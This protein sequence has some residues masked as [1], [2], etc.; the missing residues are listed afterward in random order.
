[1]A[2]PRSSTQVENL[3]WE[4]RFR[5][6]HVKRKRRDC[7]HD[8][9][10]G[11]WTVLFSYP[12]DFTPVCATELGMISK[13]A[14]EFS[15]RNCKIIG[16]SMDSVESHEAWIKDVNETQD[17]EVDFPLIMTKKA[18]SQ[19]LGMCP[20]KRLMLPLANRT[21]TYNW[22]SAYGSR[23]NG[24]PCKRWSQFLRGTSLLDALQL[25]EYTK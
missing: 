22:T 1:M 3:S 5:T 11:S 2:T 14:S 8:Y 18:P 20:P 15:A 23:K 6:F 19:M 10:T 13:L 9:I 17:T 16:L 25:S 4:M 12:T 21:R 7:F 24:V